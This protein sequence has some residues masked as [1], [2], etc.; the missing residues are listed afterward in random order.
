[1]RRAKIECVAG[2]ELA[3]RVA[4]PRSVT[5]RWIRGEVALW[6]AAAIA[7]S[8][9]LIELAQ[10]LRAVDGSPSILLAP[11]LMALH[12]FRVGWP[13]GKPRAIGVALV[14]VGLALEIV[15]LLAD[16][17]SL[18][19]LGLPPTVVGIALLAGRPAFAVAALSLWIVPP[20]TAV[21]VQASPWLESRVAELASLPFRRFGFP[22]E[23]T[24]PLIRAPSGTLELIGSHTGISIAILLAELGWYAGVRAERRL[25]SLVS[26]ALLWMTAAPVVQ[27]LAATLAV[28]CLAAGYPR[29]ARQWLDYGIGI[30][31]GV[32]SI[33]WVEWRQAARG[34]VVI[35]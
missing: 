2:I 12:A 4:G 23:A 1:M 24:G 8:P 3:P 20:P 10:S 9:V 14:A 21:F 15:G 7:L 35:R 5:L 17:G 25:P 16:T 28:G 34:D 18:A 13:R 22:I 31:V 32:A 27:V 30:A 6:L 26:R 33:A 11:G 29:A 19:R